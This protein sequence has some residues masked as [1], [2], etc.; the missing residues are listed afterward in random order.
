V[1]GHI[2][3]TRA[4]AEKGMFPAIDVLESLSRIMSEIVADGHAQVARRIRRLM[5]RYQEIE[6]L[7]RLGEIK[8]GIDKEIDLAVAAHPE[9][10]SFREQ[11]IRK[12]VRFEDTLRGMAVLAKK[13]T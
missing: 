2:V 11:D 4:L 12:P 9:I 8:P 3:L 10:Q 1:D 5:A 7:L 13:F 6:L